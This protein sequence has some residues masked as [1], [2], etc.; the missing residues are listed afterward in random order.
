MLTLVNWLIST[1]CVFK[2]DSIP[3]SGG[4]EIHSGPLSDQYRAASGGSVEGSKGIGAIC[5]VVYKKML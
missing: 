2:A 3:R 4:Q 5:N 1:G